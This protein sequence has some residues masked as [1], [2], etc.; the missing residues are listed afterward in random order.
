LKQFL[1]FEQH[2]DLADGIP[3]LV[4][5]DRNW[6]SDPHMTALRSIAVISIPIAS[7]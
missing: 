1:W 2:D 3:L 7:D 5:F 6:L 4:N